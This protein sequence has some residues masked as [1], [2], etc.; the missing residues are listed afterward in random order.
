[1][2]YWLVKSEP[3]EC[4]IDHFVA[5]GANSIRWDGVRNYQA[6]NFLRQMSVGDRVL[7]YHSSCQHIGIAGELEVVA[8]SY[9]DPTQFDVQSPYVDLKSSQEEPRWSA[10][11]L[12]LIEKWPAIL[13]LNTLKQNATQLEGLQVIA[14]GAR[15]SVMPVTHE[16]WQVIQQLR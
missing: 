1:M 12:V 5:A 7:L 11:D 16:H 10:V 14:K 3:D 8:S 9:P 6:R 2:K 4:G 15:L 13:P